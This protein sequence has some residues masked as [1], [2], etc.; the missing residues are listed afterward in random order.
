[1][2]SLRV[3]DFELPT[4]DHT[5]RLKVPDEYRNTTNTRIAPPFTLSTL[6]RRILWIYGR[7][8]R[9]SGTGCCYTLPTLTQ[10]GLKMPA[11]TYVNWEFQV[12]ARPFWIQAEN[13]E[14]VFVQSVGRDTT[15]QPFPGPL[16]ALC[17]NLY[18]CDTS[19]RSYTR[20]EG[21][22]DTKSALGRDHSRTYPS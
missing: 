14:N 5:R 7:C 6:R 17:K 1:M 10:K 19:N 2:T 11:N 21:K 9:R 8:P 12:G 15:V 4:V 3:A 20:R 22:F 13:H 18:F 16:S